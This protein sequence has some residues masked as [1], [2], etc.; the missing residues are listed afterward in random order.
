[1]SYHVMVSKRAERDFDAIFDHI[2]QDSLRNAV[3]C[4]DNLT[5]RLRVLIESP[6]IGRKHN[7]S[8]TKRIFIIDRYKIYYRIIDSKKRV[9]ISYIKHERQS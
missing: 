3:S 4:T 7:G 2:A 9:W 8:D 5:S 6:R 1:M